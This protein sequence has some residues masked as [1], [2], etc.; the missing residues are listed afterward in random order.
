MRSLSQLIGSGVVQE[1]RPN[2][3]PADDLVNQGLA[4]VTDSHPSPLAWQVWRPKTLRL[5]RLLQLPFE[6]G[7]ETLILN[8]LVFVWIDKLLHKRGDALSCGFQFRWDTEINH[9]VNLQRAEFV[10]VT[11]EQPDCNC[12]STA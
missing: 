7:G 4:D 8:Q 1:A 2:Y 3:G 12:M 6:P 10:R 11:A 9:R 5:H